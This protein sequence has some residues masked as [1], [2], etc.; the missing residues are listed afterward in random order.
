LAPLFPKQYAAL[1]GKAWADL[2]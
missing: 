1:F 2:G